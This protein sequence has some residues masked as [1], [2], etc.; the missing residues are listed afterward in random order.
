MGDNNSPTLEINGIFP[1]LII[2]NQGA[3]SYNGYQAFNIYDGGLGGGGSIMSSIG[4]NFTSYPNTGDLILPT[5]TTGSMI[6]NAANA[7]IVTGNT[8]GAIV[9]QTGATSLARLRIQFDG[10]TYITGNT[11]IGGALT[12]GNVSTGAAKNGYDVAKSTT[13]ANIDNIS[14]SVF[15]NGVPAVS[16]IT[17]TLNYFWSAVTNLTGGKFFGNT[18]TGSAVTTTPTVVGSSNGP[19]GSGGDTV[20]AIVQDQDLKRVYQIIYTQTVTASSCAI[21][22]TRIM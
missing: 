15:A 16:S 14:A 21:V 11:W 1:R 18:S 19:L 10:N 17:G 6:I 20:T 3:Y 22:I 8:N 4:W 7:S 12:L 9:F 5:T 13:F 2:K